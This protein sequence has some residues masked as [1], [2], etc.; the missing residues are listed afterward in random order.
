NYLDRAPPEHSG[1]DNADFTDRNDPAGRAGNGN[2]FIA[3]PLAAADGRVLV[4]DRIVALGYADL[5]PAILRRVAVEVLHCL[6]YYATRPENAGRYPWPAPSCADGSAFG[7]APDT[8]PLSLGT[9][10]DTPFARTAGS[11]G[12]RM[13][14]RWWRTA[15]RTPEDLAELPTAA[16]ACR[17]A[18]PPDDAGPVRNALPGTPA[19]EAQTSGF[20]GNAWWVSWQPFVAYALARGYAP[21]ASAAATCDDGA[22]FSITDTAG[23][24]LARDEEV[25][26]IASADCAR[27]P[28]CD[29]SAG[30]ARVLL[31]DAASH[32]IAAFP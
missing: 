9:V 24:T 31:D 7:A 14:Q 32:G 3:G 21:D 10:P 8:A 17:I 11:S 18:I 20:E 15:A 4:N 5:M 19:G 2:G 1:E 23:R 16:D 25:A 12:E 30:C 22:C 29:P 13:L 27:A 26:V 6:R 28:R